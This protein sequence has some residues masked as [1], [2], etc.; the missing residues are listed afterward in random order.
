MEVLDSNDK[1]I[2]TSDI[3][4]FYEDN[5]KHKFEFE[6]EQRPNKVNMYEL[7]PNDEWLLMKEKDVI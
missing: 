4:V 7:G 1:I 2:G 5:K 3:V 6:L